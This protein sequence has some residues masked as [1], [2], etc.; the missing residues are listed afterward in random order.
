MAPIEHPP[1][2]LS[3][4]LMTKTLEWRNAQIEQILG[5]TT[6]HRRREL[7]KIISSE[8]GVILLAAAATIETVAY[9]VFSV[10]SL[11]LFPF[12]KTLNKPV[13]K[14]LQSSSF[15]IIWG[16]SVGLG[17]NSVMREVDAN[18]SYARRWLENY[19]SVALVRP[20]DRS[21][22]AQNDLLIEQHDKYAAK[23]ERGANFIVKDVLADASPATINLF[24]EC[25]TSMCM[26]IVSKAVYIYTAGDKKNHEI[27]NF[28][29][30]TTKESILALREELKDEETLRHLHD[31]HA[32]PDQFEENVK[33][34]NVQE[35]FNKIRKS[36]ANELQNSCLTTAC[37]ARA[38]EILSEL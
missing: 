29:K 8:L 21:F 7:G 30:Y 25:A 4:K 32:T 26:F 24:N 9:A 22:I 34:P 3:S 13:V 28:F 31:L 18:E 38:I 27:P 1:T 20:E 10:A 17:F 5:G 14:L 35:A 36:A 19:L 12:T 6:T 37:W 23:I 15:T 11:A 33:I 16:L 2:C